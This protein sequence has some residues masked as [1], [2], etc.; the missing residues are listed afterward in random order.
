[1]AS[2]STSSDPV[3]L[4]Y[5]KICA[6]FVDKHTCALYPRQIALLKQVL[7]VNVNGYAISDFS[8]LQRLF[9]LAYAKL[10]AGHELFLP[11]LCDLIALTALPFRRKK[12]NEEFL[13]LEAVPALIGQLATMLV[14]TEPAIQVAVAEALGSICTGTCLARPES[15]AMSSLD[16]RPVPRDWSQQLVQQAGV[17][18]KAIQVLTLLIHDAAPEEGQDGEQLERMELLLFPIMDLLREMSSWPENAPLFTQEG[19]VHAILHILANVHDLSD[20]LLPSC[21]EILWNVLECTLQDLPPEED[22]N[23][24]IVMG[25]PSSL[26]CLSQLFQ[27]F[28]DKGYRQQD[29]ALRNECVILFSL[30]AQYPA[31]L[32]ALHKSG[33]VSKFGHYAIASEARFTTAGRAHYSE[34]CAH[35]LELKQL[36]WTLLCDCNSSSNPNPIS[37]SN[38]SSSS[39]PSSDPSPSQRPLFT[40]LLSYLRPDEPLR[41]AADSP[42]IVLSSWSASEIQILQHMALR[43]LDCLVPTNVMD[44]QACGGPT[45]LLG[46]LF[47]PDTTP[48][49]RHNITRI[50]SRNALAFAPSLIA[51]EII[52]SFVACFHDSATR[53]DI[54]RHVGRILAC[55][56][57]APEPRLREEA[58]R[59][60]RKASGVL[61]LTSVLYYRPEEDLVSQYLIITV[62]DMVRACV[63]GDAKNEVKFI[64]QDGVEKCLELV[65]QGPTF[66]QGQVLG[67]I[68]DLCGNAKARAAFQLWRGAQNGGQGGAS[69]LL[70]VW[71]EEERRR[72]IAR[73]KAGMIENCY[74]PLGEEAEE[75]D[76]SKEDESPAFA[77]LMHAIETA[78]DVIPDHQFE[79]AA[80]E[81]DVRARIYAILSQLGFDAV[82]EKLTA[83]KEVRR[84]FKTL[85]N[86]KKP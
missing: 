25:S 78:Q 43:T 60:F 61:I 18:Q 64:Q 72:G 66:C 2:L 84:P 40:V 42:P 15:S 26:V 12:A 52:E 77:R 10:E 14:S 1:M 13:D 16:Q 74:D 35:D 86:P 69:M 80:H 3:T 21:I 19:A 22:Q 38:P 33:L 23:A 67:I 83:N 11:P 59:R 68:A 76:G 55:I 53:V 29:K 70:D 56:C 24:L 51:P 58:R 79:L 20:D 62:L 85:K 49:Q 8:S 71:L 63:L 7:R 82:T 41:I 48:E 45:H 5:D 47:H 6:T 75:E 50:L 54:R 36:L 73:P 46:L 28:L 44:F 17:V 32:P 37:N 65:T 39:D 57:G 81:L 30:L 27:L 31:N 4:D 9:Q 34:P